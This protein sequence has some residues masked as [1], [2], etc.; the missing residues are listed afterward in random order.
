MRVRWFG[1]S[2]FL[3]S[4]SEGRVFIDPFGKGMSERAKAWNSS[5]SYPEIEDVEADVLL[6]THD[7]FDHNGVEAIGGDPKEIRGAGTHESPVGEIV[8]VNSE[9]DD[10]AGTQRGPNTI[11][12]FSLDGVTVAHFGDFGQLA[13]RPEQRAALGDL[14]VVFFPVGAGPTTPPA[15]G[16]A[17]LRDLAPAVLVPMHYRSNRISFLEPPE[18]FFEALGWPVEETGTEADVTTEGGPRVLKLT[19]T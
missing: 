2:A 8:G 19:F 13:L 16:A 1:Q 10:A 5:W 3:L 7:H 6:V 17:L 14:D 11:F 4:G 9:H 18:P 15:E 12:R